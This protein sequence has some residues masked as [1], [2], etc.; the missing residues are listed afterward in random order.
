VKGKEKFRSQEAIVEENWSR[1][2]IVQRGGH[3]RGRHRKFPDHAC[4]RPEQ[5][6]P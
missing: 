2:S 1:R 6:F 3:S 4:H 5:T